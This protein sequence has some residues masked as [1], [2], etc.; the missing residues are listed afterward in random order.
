MEKKLL[1]CMKKIETFPKK[2]PIKISIIPIFKI[3][4]MRNKVRKDCLTRN[5]AMRDNPM[6][7]SQMSI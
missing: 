4:L 1:R 3:K 2:S 5:K 7:S 6:R